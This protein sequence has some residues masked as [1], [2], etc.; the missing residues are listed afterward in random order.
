M[1]DDHEVT[2]DFAG[3]APADSDARFAQTGVLINESALFQ[4]GL[5]AFQEFN[6]IRDEYYGDTQDPRTA[7]KRKLYRYRTFGRDA[8]IFMLD[9]RSFRDQEAEGA[10]LL[11]PP[12]ADE[13]YDPNRTMLGDAQRNELYNDLLDAS[14]RG[15]TWKFILVPEPIQALGPFL[16][17]DRFE[18]YAYERAELLQFLVDHAIDNVVFITADIHSTVIN[19]LAYRFTPQQSPVATPY[20]E[21]STGSVAYA[22]PLGPTGVQY[23]AVVPLLGPL[24][25]SAYDGLDR[26][27]KDDLV[28]DVLD[29][30]ITAEGYSPIG[31]AG[32]SVPAVLTAGKWVSLHTFG[33][34]EFDIDAETQQ[35]TVTTYGID[36]YDRDALLADPMGVIGRTPA[37]VSRMT[38]DPR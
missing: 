37:V 32:S 29:I 5:Q 38:V 22:A 9:A 23:A 12:S 21:I 26:S 28:R 18:G 8:A 34:T 3:G 1:I 24:F 13:I 27:A 33:W 10:G 11:S 19:D 25:A 36:W 15:I 4:N 6:P 31:L 14:E 30:L 35:L 2:N 7:G 20:W 17:G 16:I